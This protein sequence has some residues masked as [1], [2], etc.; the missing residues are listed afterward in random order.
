MYYSGAHCFVFG[1][2]IDI[3][4]IKLNGLENIILNIFNKAPIRPNI[5]SKI[6]ALV[7][8]EYF[9]FNVNGE[10]QRTIATLGPNCPSEIILL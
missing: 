3:K 2:Y 4:N 8:N 1:L 6:Y 10:Y 9:N 7:R 5:C